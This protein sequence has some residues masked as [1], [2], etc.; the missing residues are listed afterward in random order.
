M[1]LKALK[2]INLRHLTAYDWRYEIRLFVRQKNQCFVEY[3]KKNSL[4]KQIQN[5]LKKNNDL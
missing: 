5:I 2:N 3:K 1:L 4:D